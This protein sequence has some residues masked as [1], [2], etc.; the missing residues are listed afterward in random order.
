M[1]KDPPKSQSLKENDRLLTHSQNQPPFS[2]DTDIP[3]PVSDV[4]FFR[5]PEPQTETGPQ[6][7]C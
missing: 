3:I 5:P 1:I 7:L 6:K 4:F 2:I